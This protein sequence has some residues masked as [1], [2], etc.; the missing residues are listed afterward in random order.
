M[1]E[2]KKMKWQKDLDTFFSIY[3]SFVLEGFVDD[4][5]PYEYKDGKTEY[6]KLYEYF[7]K[8]YSGNIDF[9]KKRRVII[10][11]P[12]ES[13][14]KR[15]KI[16]DD[17]YTQ[18]D[19][20]IN[21]SS[22]L[23][24]H[25]WDIT[26]DEDMDKLLIDHKSSGPSLDFSRIHYAVTE[27]TERLAPF[28]ALDKF[29]D[30]FSALFGAV[31]ADGG[32]PNGYL[33]VIKM[34]SRLLS[35]DG[36]SGG[37]S[38][39]EL[40]I[41]RQLLSIAQSLN[42]GNGDTRP[43]GQKHKLIVLANRARDLP[44]W[45][46]DENA[47]PFIK[48]ITVARPSEENKIDYFH[49]ML[50][51]NVF[52][53]RFMAR[54]EEIKKDSENKG[55]KKNRVEKKFLAYTNDFGMTTLRKYRSFVAANPIDNPEKLGFSISSFRA[56]DTTN[57]WDDEARISDMLNI[58]QTVSEK[59]KGQEYALD[60]AQ[61]ILTRAAEGLDRAE[62]P[63]APRV[64]LFLAGPTGTGKTELCKQIA[65]AIFGSE[66]R[67]VRF[68]MSEYGQAESDQKLFGAPPG[69]VGYEEGGKLTNAIKKE[70]FSLILFDEIEKAHNSILD[71]F[72]QILGDG[73]LTDGKGET[74]RFTDCIIVITSNAGV[75]SL[76]GMPQ[77]EVDE[78]MNGD[79]RPDG[80][81]N[82]ARVIEMED[83]KTAEEIYASVR[84]HLRYNVK[85][86][87]HCKLKKPELYGRIADSIVY[88]NYIGKDSVGE[89][90]KAKIADV[91][92]SA[93]EVM[94]IKDIICPDKVKNAIGKYCQ[95]CKVRALGARGIIKSTGQLFSGSLS[96]FLSAY[97]RGT[98]GKSK[99]D[100]A[101]KV[102]QCDCSGDINSA[103]DIKW[104]VKDGGG[105]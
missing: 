37:L 74:V 40:M 10:Y 79:K 2:S 52:N 66:D 72:L 61:E 103:K 68:D 98:D 60:A 21:Y 25:F 5:Q 95:D 54:Y 12:V 8:A 3:N 41:F 64:V 35:R 17:N 20:I 89:I 45:F 84:E 48:I 36:N 69:Y 92:K 86:Y 87:F 93:I 24:Q 7:D 43:K 38:G 29:K 33:F 91:I 44:T 26:H 90:A 100:L 32:E 78:L 94:E 76:G 96:D 65:E 63:N 18:K 1:N 14:D 57:P 50:E 34:T 30:F 99:R 102:L 80:E 11:D 104:S 88:Y 71:K 49:E 101:G 105:I 22:L 51:Q 62:N 73:R 28:E 56:G 13:E 42:T 23:S 67:I 82:M 15:F 9:D 70:P 97:V 47:N 83:E 19:K 55:E 4:E 58:K 53:E 85:E 59:I 6:C 39:E 27:G 16:F 75:F 77:S 81:M 31:S 46:I